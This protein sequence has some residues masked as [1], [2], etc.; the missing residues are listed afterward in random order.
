MYKRQQSACYFWE[1]HNLNALADNGDID[2]ISH[3]INGGSLG[4]DERRHFYQ[5][6]LQVLGA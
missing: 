5:H 4:L 3:I 2:R 1:S 6:A